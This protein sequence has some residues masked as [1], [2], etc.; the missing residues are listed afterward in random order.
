RWI[1][2]R[3]RVVERDDDGRPIRFVGTHADVTELANAERDALAATRAKTQFLA[4]V[5][6]ELRTPLNAVLGL[7]EAVL[8][9]T[10]GPISLRQEQSLRTIHESGSHLLGL[11][12]D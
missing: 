12:N 7:S 4:N 1:L 9:G 3:G 2:T 8:T 10:L 6:H 11:I 5:S